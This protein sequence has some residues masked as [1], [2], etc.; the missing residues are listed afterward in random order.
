MT[1]VIVVD[2][3]DRPLSMPII[4]FDM[5]DARASRHWRV[6]SSTSLGA[7]TLRHWALEDPSYFEKLWDRDEVMMENLRTALR[8]TSEEW[9]SGTSE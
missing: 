3:W 4:F 8:E 5:I 2:H 9:H 6:F 7:V 1:Y